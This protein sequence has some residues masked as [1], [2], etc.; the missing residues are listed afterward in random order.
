MSRPG[1]SAYR[2][3]SRGRRG[4]PL[5]GSGRHRATALCPPAL[6]AAAGSTPCARCSSSRGRP[7]R[8]AAARHRGRAARDGRPRAR[9]VAPGA[10]AGA[11]PDR[12]S[13]G[14]RPRPRPSSSPA[15]ARLTSFG[16]GGRASGGSG[17]RSPGGRSGRSAARSSWASRRGRRGSRSPDMR[18]RASGPSSGDQALTNRS[19]HRPVDPWNRTGRLVRTLGVSIRVEETGRT[20][21][22]TYP[23][24]DRDHARRRAG[25]FPLRGPCRR[26]G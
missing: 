12:S 17:W 7:A 19:R 14:A 26:T 1:R 13:H 2:V 22:A 8:A 23:T 24:T 18:R 9:R 3:P 10:A 11:S 6:S 21:H 4:S 20:S 25:R 15:S 5:A 16:R